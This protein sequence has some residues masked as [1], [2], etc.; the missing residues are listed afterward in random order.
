MDLLAPGSGGLIKTTTNADQGYGGHTG[1]SAA[2]PHATGV[3]ALLASASE[4]VRLSVEDLEH[5]MQY[6]ADDLESPFYDQ[7]TAWGRL[8]AGAA[9]EFIQENRV[10]HFSAVPG[11]GSRTFLSSW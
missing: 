3:A 2:A 6:T 10:L 7:R 5:I 4:Q 9:L 8:N 11:R 1:T